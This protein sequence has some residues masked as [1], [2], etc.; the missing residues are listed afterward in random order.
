MFY[1]TAVL[2]VFRVICCLMDRLWCSCRM[3]QALWLR[4][5]EGDVDDDVWLWVDGDE[6]WLRSEEP[7]GSLRRR[8]D[9]HRNCQKPKSAQ[10]YTQIAPLRHCLVNRQLQRGGRAVHLSR[11]YCPHVQD[12]THSIYSQWYRWQVLGRVS[13]SN[14]CLG[15]CR[16]ES[17]GGWVHMLSSALL[18]YA[19][20]VQYDRLVRGK[21]SHLGGGLRIL[22]ALS[23]LGQVTVQGHNYSTR[24]DFGCLAAGSLFLLLF[25]FLRSRTRPVSSKS[26][27]TYFGHAISPM[28]QQ[29][30]ASLAE[31]CCAAILCTT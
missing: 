31:A 6:E 10:C 12:S 24:G 1:P 4:L 11:L 13:I 25:R 7:L 29:I 26:N 27:R 22:R 17:Q 18:W 20:V 14:Q 23:V 28:C 8:S 16:R 30:P 9:I 21:S 19:A 2:F 3:R 5:I 15:G